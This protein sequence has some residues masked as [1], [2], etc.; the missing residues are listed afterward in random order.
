MQYDID[1]LPSQFGSWYVGIVIYNLFEGDKNG[2]LERSLFSLRDIIKRNITH[3]T[4][5][6]RSKKN[7][8]ADGA[9]YGTGSVK[10]QGHGVNREWKTLPLTMKESQRFRLYDQSDKAGDMFLKVF[11]SFYIYNFLISY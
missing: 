10:V 9:I 11:F 1:Q 3:C 5:V 6:H 2:K 7:R 8:P 4:N